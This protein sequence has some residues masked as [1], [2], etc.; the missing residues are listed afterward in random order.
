MITRIAFFFLSTALAAGVPARGAAAAEALPKITI[1][2]SHSTGDQ[3]PLFVAADAGYFKAHGVD[4]V[5]DRLPA[6]QGIPALLNGEVQFMSIGAGDS[7]AAAAQGIHIKY[8]AAFAPYY[9]FGLWAQPKYA[10]AAKLKGRKF[11][12]ASLVGTNYITAVLELR[13]LGLPPTDVIMTPLGRAHNTFAALIAGS[14]AA[15][16]TSPPTSYALQRRGFVE[17]VD[18]LPKRIP[19][20]SAGLAT[21]D[22]YVAAHRALA[23]RAADAFAEGL[24]REKTDRAFTE[25]VIAKHLGIKGQAALDRTYDFYRATIGQ[26][27]PMPNAAM[28]VSAQSILGTHNSK[29]KTVDPKSLIDTSFVAQAMARGTK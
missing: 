27:W 25:R 6:Q 5:L 13:Q 16:S 10:S 22:S 21:L 9:A 19:N 26:D 15:I 29:L 2:Y 1:S 4:A 14:V 8:V 11:G 7:L 23:Q 3:L 12:V 17:L 28:F 20:L 24:R 18:L